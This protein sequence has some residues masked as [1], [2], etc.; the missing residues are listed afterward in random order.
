VHDGCVI[1]PRIESEQRELESV[2]TNGFS[3]ASAA[4]ATVLGQ[5]RQD[6]VREAPLVAFVISLDLHVRLGRQ[7]LPRGLVWPNDIDFAGPLP[8]RR[9]STADNG[10]DVRFRDVI[11]DTARDVTH[12]AITGFQRH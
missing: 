8:A 5:H 11:A 12:R 3:M 2:L 9:N 7:V 1:L 10:S 4:V 6:V